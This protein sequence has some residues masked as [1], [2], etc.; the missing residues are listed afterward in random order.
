MTVF[1]IAPFSL[2]EVP[3]SGYTV[4]LT[5]HDS[6]GNKLF[7]AVVYEA[8]TSQVI[9]IP[10]DLGCSDACSELRLSV[11]ALNGAGIGECGVITFSSISGILV[12]SMQTTGVAYTSQHVDALKS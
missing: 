3:I 4:N 12:H 11:A 5:Q 2:P 10:G 9:P 6:D 8:N 1:W 7:G